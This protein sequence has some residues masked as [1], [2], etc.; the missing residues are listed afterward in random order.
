ML[1]DHVL[2]DFETIIDVLVTPIVTCCVQIDNCLLFEYLIIQ[3]F[4]EQHVTK[5]KGIDY[6]NKPYSTSTTFS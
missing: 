3:R 1:H 5:M 6:E 2:F 4:F